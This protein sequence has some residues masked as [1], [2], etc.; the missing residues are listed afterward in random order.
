MKW[1]NPM[2]GTEAIP[3]QPE[4]RSFFMGGFE[5]STHRLRSGRR[6]DLIATTGHDRFAKLDY[7][8]LH[9]L[10]LRVD[11]EGVRWHL[12]EQTPGRYDFSTIEPIVHAARATGTQV[13]WD[14]CHFGWPDH[15]D[16]FKADYVL[17]LA[18]Y[19]AG[20]AKWLAR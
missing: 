19:G 6:L 15:L 10:D 17:S 7:Q 1:E 2:P 9:R 20:F 4:F 16:L 5:C 8:R 18:R 12:V 11:R 14:L 3:Q 13:I